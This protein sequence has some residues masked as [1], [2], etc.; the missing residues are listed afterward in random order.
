M[1]ETTSALTEACAE[2]AKHPFIAVDTEFMRDSTYWPKLCLI[3]VAGG[4]VEVII[5]P[6]AKDIDLK[7]FHDLLANEEV[8]KVF[9]AARQDVEI[10][11]HFGGV[12]PHPLVDTQVAAMVCGFGDS[13]GYETS[14]AGSLIFRLT[15]RLDLPIGADAPSRTNNFTMHWGTSPTFEMLIRLCVMKWLGGTAPIGLKKKWIF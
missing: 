5:D 7:A 14:F 6:L 13:V 2:L 9:H 4:D 10:F 11:F 1:I 12:I 3:Q 15:N 8:V